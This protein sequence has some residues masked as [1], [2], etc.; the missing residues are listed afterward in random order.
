MKQMKKHRL[1]TKFTQK[2]LAQKV[3]V[4]PE[5]ISYLECGKKTPSMKTLNKIAE[6]LNTTPSELLKR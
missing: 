3:G 1:K 2:E 6:I 4:T 5:Y